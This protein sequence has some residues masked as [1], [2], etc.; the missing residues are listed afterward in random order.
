MAYLTQRVHRGAAPQRGDKRHAAPR[1]GPEMPRLL[2]CRIL[3]TRYS[4]SARSSNAFRRR[5]LGTFQAHP[6]PGHYSD[7]LLNIMRLN[8]FQQPSNYFLPI[9]LAPRAGP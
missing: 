1:G 3:L 8:Y 7:R 6:N 2:C 4:K 5:A 9:T